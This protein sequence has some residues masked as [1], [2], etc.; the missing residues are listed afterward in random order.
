M[1][2]KSMLSLQELSLELSNAYGIIDRLDDSIL[3]TGLHDKEDVSTESSS[4]LLRAIG[5]QNADRLDKVTLIRHLD[6]IH[7]E[8]AKTILA[9]SKLLDSTVIDTTEYLRANL[10]ANKKFLKL[11]KNN[12]NKAHMTLRGYDKQTIQVKGKVTTL[13]IFIGK[14][15]E[16]I[17]LTDILTKKMHRHVTELVTQDFDSPDKGY[18]ELLLKEVGPRLIL[19]NNSEI[20]L[21]ATLDGVKFRCVTIR[22]DIKDKVVYTIDSN[23]YVRL[24]DSFSD[25]IDV[26]DAYNSNVS[27]KGLIERYRKDTKKN[28]VWLD[29][30]TKFYVPYYMTLFRVAY[31]ISD[32][33]DVYNQ[34]IQVDNGE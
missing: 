2:Y 22:N 14:V 9:N 26:I 6:S 32:L 30:V 31:L 33:L 11:A 12:P 16:L 21:D 8:V 24:Y 25:L 7:Y 18:L 17:Y 5:I 13:D 10:S 23:D 34:I 28:R 15:V 3:A 4:P 27:L 19:L 20:T 1:M 29:M